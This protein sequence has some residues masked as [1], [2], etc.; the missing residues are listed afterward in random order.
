MIFQIRNNVST[1]EKSLCGTPSFFFIF[2]LKLQLN[3]SNANMEKFLS[4]ESTTDS[5]FECTGVLEEGKTQLCPQ[6]IYAHKLNVYE[7]LCAICGSAAKPPT[8]DLCTT[9][10]G[11]IVIIST[12]LTWFYLDFSFGGMA[13]VWDV[14]PDKYS[15]SGG[16]DKSYMRW[17]SW[18]LS[19]FESVLSLSHVVRFCFFMFWGWMSGNVGYVSE[20]WVWFS[21]LF[22]FIWYM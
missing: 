6:A 3:S 9:P 7:T 11:I 15:C 16:R 14:R 5:R 1:K 13:S 17:W 12:Y 10:L 19:A 18:A 21:I 8:I 4:P 2:H 20:I 22:H